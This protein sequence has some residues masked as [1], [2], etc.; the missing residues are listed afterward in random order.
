MKAGVYGFCRIDNLSQ[1]NNNPGF[2][3]L[4]FRLLLVARLPAGQGILLLFGICLPPYLRKHLLK[5]FQNQAISVAIGLDVKDILQLHDLDQF[6]G[7]FGDVGKLKF[8]I[9]DLGI[10]EYP[11]EGFE[12]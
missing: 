9:V 2:N 7:I 1:F 10:A 3:G 8:G 11:E 6:H 12:C 5:S 4:E